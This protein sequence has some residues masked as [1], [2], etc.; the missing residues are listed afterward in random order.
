MTKNCL[1]IKRNQQ[2]RAVHDAAEAAQRRDDERADAVP[3]Q[4]HRGVL[5]VQLGAWMLSSGEGDRLA[6]CMHGDEAAV[7]FYHAGAVK[8]SYFGLF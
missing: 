5:A 8:F 6:A 1:L 4:R 3:G 7:A 2:S